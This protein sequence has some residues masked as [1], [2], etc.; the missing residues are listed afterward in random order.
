[1]LFIVLYPLSI[2]TTQPAGVDAA[3]VVA[4]TTVLQCSMEHSES[5]VAVVLYKPVVGSLER[6]AK[7]HEVD[8][9]LDG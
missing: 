6:L 3:D 9:S 2:Q 4:V 7:I 1:M 8:V 5:T